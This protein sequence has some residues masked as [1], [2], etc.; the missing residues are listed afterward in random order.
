MAKPKRTLETILT[1]SKI[2]EIEGEPLY[3]GNEKY[4]VDYFSIN[5]DLLLDSDFMDKL[6]TYGKDY[7][8]FHCYLKAN[9]LNSGRYY[10]FE[11]SIKRI[12]KNYCLNYNAEFAD[13]WVIYKDLLDSQVLF[14]LED[15]RYFEGKIITDPYIVYNYQKTNDQRSKNREDQRA[16]REA[17]AKKKP[18]PPIPIERIPTAPPDDIVIQG[19]DEFDEF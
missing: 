8:I 18:A 14:L 5:A 3:K 4:N 15:K 2:E 7:F 12:I 11:K 1:N 16:H 10:V 19:L 6:E 13:I 17:E 9:M